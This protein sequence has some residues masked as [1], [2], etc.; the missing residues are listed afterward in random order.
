M[1]RT[2][3]SKQKVF[4]PIFFAVSVFVCVT[5]FVT[6][7]MHESL[8]PA[9]N[10]SSFSFFNIK[11]VK[12][13]DKVH[14]ANVV[15]CVSTMGR[16]FNS[17]LAKATNVPKDKLFAA[18]TGHYNI[19]SPPS[20]KISQQYPM[21]VYIE[22][23]Y[24]DFKGRPIVRSR[25][26]IKNAEY[27]DIFERYKW[28]KG[29][30]EDPNNSVRQFYNK[31]KKYDKG[32]KDTSET[33]LGLL[34]KILAISDTLNAVADGTIVIWLD[35]DTY[36]VKELSNEVIHY[37]RG[38]DVTYIPSFTYPDKCKYAFPY[39][40]N[41]TMKYACGICADTGILAYVANGKTRKVL[42][43][44][45]DWVLR[46][47]ITFQEGCFR[48]G[49]NREECNAGLYK[50]RSICRHTDSL[51]DVAIFG[52]SMLENLN[53]LKQQF[54]STGCL[55]HEDGDWV[56]LAKFYKVGKTM[57]CSSEHEDVRTSQF[58]ILEYI[59]HFRGTSTGL[60]KRRELWNSHE[61]TPK[62]SFV[63]SLKA[64]GGK[65]QKLQTIS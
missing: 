33:D 38:A 3:I 49:T 23:S 25:N 43:Y 31:L 9:R 59:M 17:M 29:Y 20:L 30:V 58:N 63:A 45:V 6:V 27:I 51:N 61:P 34:R 21:R 53:Y 65:G 39:E 8:L 37:L 40:S 55:K 44:Q 28:L 13:N 11:E 14:K 36:F 18:R 62:K 64:Q 10:S 26:I 15:L 22:D 24:D 2:K 56:D 42:Q 57:L 16:Y 35:M 5:C 46:N 4:L 12:G 41:E 32:S 1:K 7:Y 52:Y 54:F 19:L 50:K 47:A 60:A 48:N